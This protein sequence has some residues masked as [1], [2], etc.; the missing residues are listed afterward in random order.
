[1]GGLLEEDGPEVGFNVFLKDGAS[2][3]WETDGETPMIETTKIPALLPPSR[4]SANAVFGDRQARLSKD[5]K[6]VV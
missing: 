4:R 6:S 5:R 3:T 2:D 1:M